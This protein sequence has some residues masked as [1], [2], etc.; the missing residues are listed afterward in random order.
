MSERIFRC[1]DRKPEFSI[2]YSVAGEQKHYHVCSDCIHLDCFSKYII[3]KT[4]I[5]TQTK[6]IFQNEISDESVETEIINEKFGET[7]EQ[8][9]NLSE[10]IEEERSQFCSKNK[11][12][13]KP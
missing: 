7:F 10:Q 8:S 3:E 9:E 13:V 2:I 6:E 4:P 1:C 12:G 11:R 5:R